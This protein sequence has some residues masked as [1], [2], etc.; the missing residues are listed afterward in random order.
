MGIGSRDSSARDCSFAHCATRALNLTMPR[1]V[2]PKTL[3]ECRTT[4][5]LSQSAFTAELAVPPE[6]YRVWDSGRR[7]LPHES[8]TEP[9]HSPHIGMTRNSSLYVFSL[10]WSVCMFALSA[11]QLETGGLLS[12]TTRAQHFD[13]YG[14]A[15]RKAERSVSRKQGL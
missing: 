1:G 11:T 15:R 7:H 4:L 6:T 5:N 8:S 9:A 2:S 13:V 10:G 3:R 14:L 12:P